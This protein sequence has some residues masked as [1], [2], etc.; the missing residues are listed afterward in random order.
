MRGIG[1]ALILVGAV[2]CLLMGRSFLRA[3]EMARWPE[4]EC[5]ILRSETGE[6]RLGD[7][8]PPEF[9]FE[10]LYGY[11][12]EGR[13]FESERFTL[14]GSP[15][16]GD[17][18]AAEELRDAHPAGTRAIC[19]VNP[20]D[21]ALAVLKVDSRA[22]GYSLWFPALFVVAGAGIVGGSFRTG[23]GR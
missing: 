14:R 3:R 9:R 19:R 1:L 15:W 22:P 4:V 7:A 12:W 6:R 2:F 21:P 11:E 13:R 18:A 8:V 23:R 10:V 17:R 16:R 20:A 5:L